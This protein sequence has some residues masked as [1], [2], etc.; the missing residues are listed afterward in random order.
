M[1]IFSI[2]TWRIYHR[3][4]IVDSQSNSRF[5]NFSLR[6]IYEIGNFRSIDIFDKLKKKYASHLF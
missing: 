1:V 2:T 6:I 5:L 3:I 4:F